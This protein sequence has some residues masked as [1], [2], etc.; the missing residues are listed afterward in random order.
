M[1]EANITDFVAKKLQEW[2]FGDFIDNFR[3]KCRKI[4]LISVFCELLYFML[5]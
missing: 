3:R 5:C 2:G 1:A 4:C